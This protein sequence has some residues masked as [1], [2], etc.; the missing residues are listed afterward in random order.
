MLKSK[1]RTSVLFKHLGFF[2]A[3]EKVAAKAKAIISKH[4]N[5]AIK[6]KEDEISNI[7]AAIVEAQTSLHI[8]RYGAVSKTYA[9]FKASAASTVRHLSTATK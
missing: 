6:D 1:L 3:K 8:L 4:F 7:T 5:E 9:A 2:S